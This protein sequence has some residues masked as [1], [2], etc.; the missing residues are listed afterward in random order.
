V[1]AAPVPCPGCVTPSP[2]GSWD[3]LLSGVPSQIT[4]PYVFSGLSPWPIW[5][6]DSQAQRAAPRAA[7]TVHFKCVDQSNPPVFCLEPGDNLSFVV[8]TDKLSTL[9][10]QNLIGLFNCPSDFVANVELVGT[11]NDDASKWTI[12]QEVK[13]FTRG[14]WVLSTDLTLTQHPFSLPTNKPDDA[15]G[16]DFVQQQAGQTS[17]YWLDSPG[18]VTW[19]NRNPQDIVWTMRD[20]KNFVSQICSNVKPYPCVPVSWYVLLVVNV[21]PS[22]LPALDFTQSTDQF[23]SIPL[24]F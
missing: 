16:S 18:H 12:S 21:G 8:Q 24:N 3:V 2:Q 10:C 6:G 22:G 15:P 14:T 19:A 5:T 7:L 20:G 13:G 17:I 9:I 1:A 11:V 4:T 23:G